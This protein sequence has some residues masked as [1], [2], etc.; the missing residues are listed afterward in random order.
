MISSGWLKRSAVAFRLT[1]PLYQPGH[2]PEPSSPALVAVARPERHYGYAGE[3]PSR[4]GTRFELRCFQLLSVEAWLPCTPFRTTGRPEA[5]ARSSS[6]TMRPLPSDGQRPQ[7]VEYHLA[8][9]GVNPAHV[10]L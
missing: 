8:R 7:Q 1:P 5:S 2:L 9:A 3:R 6:R 4:L 10:P